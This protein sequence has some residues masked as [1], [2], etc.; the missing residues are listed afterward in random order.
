MKYIKHT[1][2]KVSNKDCTRHMFL[3][4]RESKT[5]E[6][7]DAHVLFSTLISTFSLL[8]FKPLFQDMYKSHMPI[9]WIHPVGSRREGRNTATNG[10][11]FLYDSSQRGEQRVSRISDCAGSPHRS[12]AFLLLP[13]LL[14][15][16]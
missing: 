3:C 2:S 14:Y 9:M 5:L 10:F 4:T 11:A 13:C 15:F 6:S 7:S 16:L 12:M 8:I 1:Q